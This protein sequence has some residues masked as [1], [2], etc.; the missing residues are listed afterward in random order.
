VSGS[1]D[2]ALRYEEA[3]A[4]IVN[5]AVPLPVEQV[6]LEASLGRALAAPITSPVALPPWDNAGMDGY[7]IRRNDIAGATSDAP[8]RLRVTGTIAAGAD[9]TRLP[10]VSAGSSVRIMTGAPVPAGADAVVR[11]EDTDGGTEMVQIRDTRDA[12]GRG[13]IRPRG[14]DV[15]EGEVLFAAGTTLGASHLGVLASVGC[16]TVPVFRRPRVTVLSSGDELVLLDRFDDVRAGRRIVASSTYAVP[17]LLRAAGADV[18]VAPLVPDTLE[19]MVAAFSAAIDGGC[20][21]LVTTGGVSVGA[22]DYTRDALVA[23]A[24]SVD[25]WRARIRPGGPIGTGRVRGA[26]WLGLPGNPVSTMVTGTLFA[27][28]L[29]RRLGG[30]TQTAHRTLPVVMRDR[31]ET[32]AALTYFVRVSLVRGEDGALEARLAGPQGSNLMRTMA[33]ADA[34]LVVPEDCAV[35]MP[36][37]RFEA[38]LLP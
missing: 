4:A 3:L 26:T 24:G 18:T 14:E 37:A 22:H 5:S 35:V 32:P 19:A 13:N 6:P 9:P 21:L 28:P 8:A 1:R 27:W 16:A 33:E 31:F 20:D 15:G 12:V 23:L 29:I 10:A 25:F 7:A 2:G 30:H 38:I 34:L 17:A 11:V 36:G